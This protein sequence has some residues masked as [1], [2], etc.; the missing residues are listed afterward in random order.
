MCAALHTKPAVAETVTQAAR[1]EEAAEAD[2][3]TARA[4]ALEAL[5]LMDA[6]R[7][8]EAHEK[9]ERAYALF[10][11]PTVAVLSARALENVGNLVE[12]R[13]RYQEAADTSLDK[14]SPRPFRK[15]VKEAKREADR[16]SKQLPQLVV[17]V[18]GTQQAV[19]VKVDEQMLEKSQ[20]GVPTPV[21]PGEHAVIAQLDGRSVSQ[22]VSVA[23]G[24]T[25]HVT[26]VLLGP[27]IPS[28]TTPPATPAEPTHD[29]K[30]IAWVS[31]AVGGAGL[32]TG[33]VAGLVMLDA[34]SQL[35]KHCAATCPSNQNSNLD[36]FRNA[37]TVSFVGYSAGLVGLGLGVALLVKDAG[38]DASPVV[39]IGNGGARL[40]YRGR[41]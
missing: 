39:A 20:L 1:S 27:S 19:Q 9:L 37:R 8:Q 4:L 15:A 10:K 25:S 6:K 31:L 28:P 16:L 12:A 3:D 40:G 23:R 32:A 14:D 21:N 38:T 26:L 22:K 34:K 29:D 24:E 30:S 2:R 7:W 13:D 41:F 35:D 17:H 36:K 11:A 33:V 5:E 18:Q